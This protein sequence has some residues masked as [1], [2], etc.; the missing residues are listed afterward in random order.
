MGTIYKEIERSRLCCSNMHQMFFF[1]EKGI[2]LSP[3][4][5]NLFSLL[6]R[7]YD[8]HK[9]GYIEGSNIIRLLQKSDLPPDVLKQVNYISSYHYEYAMN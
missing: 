3:M 8:I 9:T 6:F 2:R 1:L 7:N 5:V 4:D